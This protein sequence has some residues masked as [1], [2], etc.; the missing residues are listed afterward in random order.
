MMP[1]WNRQWLP[2]DIDIACD[3]IQGW[4][5]YEFAGEVENE[6]HIPID[7]VPLNP[8]DD[9][10]RLIETKGK[11]LYDFRGLVHPAFFHKHLLSRISEQ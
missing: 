2:G 7:I 8:P 9:F 3:G 5:L 6:L 10:T 4:K 11:V 1:H